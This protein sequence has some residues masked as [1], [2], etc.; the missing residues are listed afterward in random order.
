VLD[1][2]SFDFDP[3]LSPFG[4]TVRLETI[5]L[6]FVIFAMLA[7][8]AIQA[9]RMRAQAEAATTAAREEKNR[10]AMP[11]LP[12]GLAL[13]PPPIV[14]K[15]RGRGDDPMRLRRDDLILIAFG[16]VPGAI[17]GG[18][19]DYAII[20]WD[21]FSVDW[22][23]LW[24]PGQG[25]LAL[26]LAVVLGTI[27]AAA[28]AGLLGAPISRWLHVAATPL[29]LG[30]G[31]GKLVMMLGGEGQGQYSNVWWATRYI[32]PGTWQSAN[33]ATPAL[34]SQ[35]VE[36]LAVLGLAVLIVAVPFALRFRIHRRGKLLAPALAPELRWV[37]L[38]GYCRFVTAVGLWAAV[39]LAVASTWRDATVLGQYR[40]EQLILIAVA[41]G[42]LLV[43]AVSWLAEK[44]RGRR[45]ASMVKLVAAAIPDDLP[46]PKGTR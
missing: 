45:V 35:A 3:T 18:R 27:T 37:I 11:V 39:R 16:A 31:L 40:A 30:L 2:I 7:F 15:V 17:L 41:A 33:P 9:G 28:V 4:L 23:R 32:G 34:P 26:T 1:V 13:E 21:Y 46:E 29:L 6:A 38:S 10:A 43:L 25:D 14:R 44:R 19:I 22:S 8:A 42:C 12:H 20:H 24:D 36:G 5:A